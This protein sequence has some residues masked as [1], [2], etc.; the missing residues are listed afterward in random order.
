MEALL[1]RAG[2]ATAV[3]WGSVAPGT[4]QAALCSPRGEAGVQWVVEGVWS[5]EIKDGG[6]SGAKVMDGDSWAR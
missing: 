3:A 1:E 2:A 5:K 4:S 6:H